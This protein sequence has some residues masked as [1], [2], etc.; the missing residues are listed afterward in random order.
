MPRKLRS[1]VTDA[2]VIKRAQDEITAAFRRENGTR[3]TTNIGY[4]S[5]NEPADLVFGPVL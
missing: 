5:N 3:V 4:Q 1:K 2:K